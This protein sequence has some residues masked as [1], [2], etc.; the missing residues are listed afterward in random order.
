MAKV[1]LNE[2]E[3]KQDKNY[4]SMK[5]YNPGDHYQQKS[6]LLDPN[7]LSKTMYMLMLRL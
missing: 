3:K 4:H 7:L 2:I 5:D 6:P 1:N